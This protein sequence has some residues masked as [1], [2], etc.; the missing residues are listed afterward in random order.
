MSSLALSLLLLVALAV[1]VALL[2][3]LRQ[4]RPRL[5]WPAGI[6]WPAELRWPG[7]RSGPAGERSAQ[8]GARRTPPQPPSGT[9]A[10]AAAAPRGEP[11]LASGDFAGEAPG[12]PP[13]ELSGEPSVTGAAQARA[14]AREP[15]AAPIVGQAQAAI[16]AAPTEPG[17]PQVA[18]EAPAAAVARA[19]A[20]RVAAPRLSEVCDCIV[21]MPLPAACAGERL[22]AIAQRFRRAG[23]KPVTIE[24]LPA[25]ETDDWGPP[26]PGRQYGALRI[27]ILMANRHGPLNA[28]EFSEFVAGVQAVAEA[29][30]ALAD[31]PDMSAV[32][33]RARDLD[34]TCAQLDAQVSVNVEAP[35]ALGPA[36]LAALAGTL[37]VAE[38]GSNRYARLG[39]QGEVVFSVALADV[40][41]RLAFLLDVPRS[42]PQADAWGQML[43]AANA[44]AQ[45]VG[46]RLVDDGGRPLADAALA[47]VGRQL[48]Q[49]YE[50]LEAIGLRAGSPLALRVF[51]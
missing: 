29:L 25:D 49:R 1:A 36:Q 16:A 41:N 46:G 22:V 13:D 18:G 15:Q 23:S 48:T 8:P 51:N 27:G 40:P 34:A 33:A 7:R 19:P 28:M 17:P 11:R 47:Q 12:E 42:S 32:L 3:N 2:Y 24:G 5:R 45:R 38:R 9:G 44:C 14:A 30:A 50:S 39:A 21:E 43:E 35:E 10:E 37:S 26:A 4:A 20:A 6:R 31:T